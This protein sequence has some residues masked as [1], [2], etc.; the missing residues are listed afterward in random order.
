MHWEA[1]A[2]LAVVALVIYALV[3]NLA[4]TDLVLLAAAAILVTLGLFSTQQRLPN[5]A[6]AMA[7]FGNEGLITVAVLFIV[8]QGLTQTGAMTWLVQPLLGRPSGVAA[9]QTRLML[10]VAV[11]S[12]V[13]NNTPIVAMFMPVVDDWCKKTRI[14]PSKLFIPLSFATVLGGCISLIGTST[15]LIVHGLMLQSKLPVLGLFELAWVGVPAAVAGMLMILL[16]SR[17]LLLDRKPAI[18]M[19]DDPRQ[20]TVEMLVEAGGSLVNQSIE[21]AG[22]RHLPGLFLA[23]IERQGQLLP[24]VEP[25]EKL[26]GG[27]RL[28][29]VGAVD[30]VVDL[31]KMRGLLP[32]T[33]QVFKLDAPRTQ[34]CLIEAV[35]SNTCRNLGKTI[36]E[37]RFRSTY[38]AAVIAVARHGQR[39]PGKIGDIV[40]QAGDTLLL[41]APPALADQLRN[42][43]DF[44]LVSKVEGSSPLRHDRA[45]IAMLILLAMVLAAAFEWLTMLHAGLLAAVAMIVTRCCTGSEARRSV[46]WETVLA[47]G[48]SFALGKA[49]ESSGAARTVAESLIGLAGSNPWVALAILYA[50]TLLF[51]EIITNNAAA[52]ILFPIAVATARS[53]DADVTPF[54]VCVMMAASCGFATPIGYQTHMMVYGPGGYRFTDFLRIGV[55]LD[56]LVMAVSVTIIPMVWPFQPAP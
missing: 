24:A 14:S 3:R 48:A 17:W 43:R 12:A 21:A 46:D 55:P 42:S 10:P 49:L 8:V 45:W 18:S 51:T 37:G 20:Y 50:V 47:I 31:R 56:L 13:L 2:S 29:F 9:A 44:F 15:N 39:V 26:R 27:D 11:L 52:V 36:R 1:W 5:A 22:L 41:E 19:S 35:V 16:T 6:Q 54:A 30:S 7:G 40:L 23:E 4:P 34:R 28:V 38:R 53:L 32:A 33:D 25:T